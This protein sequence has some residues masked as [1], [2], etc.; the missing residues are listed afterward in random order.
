M[1][2]ALVSS[3]LLT[4]W[5]AL[6]KD[7]ATKI[8]NG[9]LNSFDAELILFDKPQYHKNLYLSLAFLSK[10]LPLTSYFLLN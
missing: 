5:K 1:I 10:H 4:E 2:P 7:I 9:R 3:Y 8:E 6:R